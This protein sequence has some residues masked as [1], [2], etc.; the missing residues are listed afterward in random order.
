MLDGL[1]NKASSSTANIFT[2]GQQAGLAAANGS[3][4]SFGATKA[5]AFDAG[6]AWSGEIFAGAIFIF[7]VEQLGQIEL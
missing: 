3:F 6:F 2:Q 1:W 4:E 7:S 5:P